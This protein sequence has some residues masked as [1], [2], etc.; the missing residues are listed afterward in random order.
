MLPNL[1]AC[2]YGRAHAYTPPNFGVSDSH[3]MYVSAI[4]HLEVPAGPHVLKVGSLHALCDCGIVTKPML[5]GRPQG[6][7]T[8]H[9]F[10]TTVYKPDERA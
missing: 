4:G 1:C 8:L 3:L 6:R 5:T 7:K 9:V 10:H 2:L